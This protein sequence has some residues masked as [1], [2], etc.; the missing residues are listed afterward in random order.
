[1]SD[2]VNSYFTPDWPVPAHVKSAITFRSGGISEGTYFS[3]NFATHVGDDPAIVDSNR[4]ELKALLGLPAEPLWLEQV[5][6][7]DLVDAKSVSAGH[8]AD[9]SYSS[10]SSAVCAVLTADCLP[11]LLCNCQGDKVA[12]VH[13]GWRGLAAGILAKAI[14]RFSQNADQLMVYL[15]PAIGATEFIVGDEVKTAFLQYSPEI[16][17]QRAV[18][19]AFYVYEDRFRADLFALARAQLRCLGVHAV[20]GGDLCTVRNPSRFYSFRRDVQTGRNASL[21]WIARG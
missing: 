15:G 2:S 10:D 19:A 6:G 4:R 21:I 11:I 1:M 20:Y 14:C 16:D 3:N 12:A 13:A 9:G 7:T 18:E 5:H 8:R 17:Y